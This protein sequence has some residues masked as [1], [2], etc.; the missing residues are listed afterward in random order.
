MTGPIDDLARKLL[1]DTA[2]AAQGR[3]YAKYSGFQVGAAILHANG[4][5][6]SGANV[7][8]ASYG[9]TL[10][11]ER[12]AASSAVTA[13]GLA[14]EGQLP[15]HHWRAIA[16]S[17]R[18]GVTPCGACRQFLMEFA[19]DM[20]VLLVDSNDRSVQYLS[21]LKQLLPAAFEFN[22]PLRQS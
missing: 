16:V 4:M 1:V 10:C 9:L 12:V 3:A 19:P 22:P 18:G 15:D 6:S 14:A 17:S 11:A 8:N 20:E 2:L 21:T 13:A 7:E 5:V